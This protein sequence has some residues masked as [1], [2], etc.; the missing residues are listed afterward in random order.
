LCSITGS[1]LNFAVQ[2]VVQDP[3]H[4]YRWII[5][6]GEAADYPEV[7]C[8]TSQGFSNRM[9]EEHGAPDIWY[10]ERPRPDI[11]QFRMNREI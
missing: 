7:L 5:Q 3:E 9:A 2:S 11:V 6:H 10:W 8:W 4:E 1:I